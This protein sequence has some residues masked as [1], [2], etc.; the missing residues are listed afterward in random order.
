MAGSGTDNVT[1]IT[2][3]ALKSQVTST[4]KVYPDTTA[5]NPNK[6]QGRL[7]RELLTNMITWVQQE[8]AA[9]APPTLPDGVYFS[10]EP[11]T[12]TLGA[13][14]ITETASV[15]NVDGDDK[16]VASLSLDIPLAA[17][18]KKRKDAIVVDFVSTPA[19]YMV[20]TGLEVATTAVSPT[21][22]IPNDRLFVRYLDVTDGVVASSGTPGTSGGSV[23]TVNGQT[24]DGTKNV[25]IGAEHIDYAP[26]D[27][28]NADGFFK[29]LVPLAK[30]KIKIAL[31]QIVTKVK[32]NTTAIGTLSALTTTAKTNLVA[33][34]N[35]AA[36][37]KGFEYSLAFD[38]FL[39]ISNVSFTSW[40]TFTAIKNIRN[41]DSY[42]AQ[43]FVGNGSVTTY[44]LRTG[45]EATV[46]A[47]INSDIQAL[48]IASPSLLTTSGYTVRITPVRTAG[49]S[50]S[51]MVI[52][53]TF[54]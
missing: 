39:S 16:A 12:P 33:A 10:T 49:T 35:E 8:L 32:A 50:F 53:G 13:T 7:H 25:Q 21:P 28:D 23:N 34:I 30:L 36:G 6:T 27:T 17:T 1:L 52:K 14:S 22:L 2:P 11:G 41:V 31:D 26:A 20:V 48:K 45:S 3:A 37:S 44:A 51:E 19:V 42:S 18:G 54:E 24:P 4:I 15:V 43:L 5:L 9:I 47:N 38:T 40:A 46:I 29:T